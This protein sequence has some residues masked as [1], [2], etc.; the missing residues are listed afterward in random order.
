M[1]Q[2]T[3]LANKAEEPKTAARSPCFLSGVHIECLPFPY[4]LETCVGSDTVASNPRQDRCCAGP[5][6]RS[7]TD[8]LV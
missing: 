4:I 6:L 1:K 8:N 2:A 3:A 7:I 5:S